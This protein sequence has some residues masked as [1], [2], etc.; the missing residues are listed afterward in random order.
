MYWRLSVGLKGPKEKQTIDQQENSSDGPHSFDPG[1]GRI[2]LAGVDPFHKGKLDCLPRG[3]IDLFMSHIAAAKD[4]HLRAG[5]FL[6]E[7]LRRLYQM[8]VTGL[9][10]DRGHQGIAPSTHWSVTIPF[11]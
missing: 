7:V 10:A 4:F 11:S 3:F 8:R 9:L 5:Y 6:I 1:R 2:W